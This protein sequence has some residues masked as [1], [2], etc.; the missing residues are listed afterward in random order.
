MLKIE[1]GGLVFFI[2]I[3]CCFLLTSFFKG[4]DSKGIDS[5]DEEL[6]IDVSDGSCASPKECEKV[7]NFDRLKKLGNVKD[8]IMTY[9][10][11][12][13]ND[14]N[15]VSESALFTYLTTGAVVLDGEILYNLSLKIQSKQKK[16]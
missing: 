15:D 7:L 2:H 1:K 8:Q 16:R 11:L 6:A 13:M 4:S 9:Q 10:N 14:A 12:C 3:F 5:E